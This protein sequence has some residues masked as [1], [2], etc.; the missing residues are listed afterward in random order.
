MMVN[1]M[2]KMLACAHKNSI[3]VLTVSELADFTEMRD[4]ARFSIKSLPGSNLSF[5]LHSSLTHKSS[6][7]VMIPFY[8]RQKALKSVE[9]N[10]K[11]V[12]YTKK[13]IRGYDYV[14]LAVEPGAD[15]TF[16]F[17]FDN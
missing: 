12:A 1:T 9:C 7:T 6:L 13:I 5:D 3:P 17:A 10:G 4:E 8:Y 16:K 15:Y 2:M 14:F 11:K